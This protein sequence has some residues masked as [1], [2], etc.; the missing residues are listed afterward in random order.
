[1]NKRISTNP[2]CFISVVGPAGSGKTRLIGR[3]ICNQEKIFRPVLTKYYTFFKHY[4]QQDRQFVA[5]CLSNKIYL[6]LIQGLEWN[7]AEREQIL[8]Q[9]TLVVIDD[10]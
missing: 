5:E 1:M 9:R 8:K 4:L 3:M 10:L 2:H 6:Q 7:A